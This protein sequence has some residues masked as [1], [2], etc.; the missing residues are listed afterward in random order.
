MFLDPKGSLQLEID[1]FGA[2]I[3][4]W[5]SHEALQYGRQTRCSS[6]S[7]EA[8]EHKQS[9]IEIKVKRDLTNHFKSNRKDIIKSVR[10]IIC[11]EILLLERNCQDHFEVER[12]DTN[13]GLS[14]SKSPPLSKSREKQDIDH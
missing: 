1:K 14:Q 2:K 8:R 6:F 4:R 12:I 9:I 3:L 13:L 7:K 10:S 5:K 11:V